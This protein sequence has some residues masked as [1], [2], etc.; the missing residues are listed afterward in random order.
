MGSNLFIQ[1]CKQGDFGD[2]DE[3]IKLK[4]RLGCKSFD[5][6][7]KNVAYD[8]FNPKISIAEGEVQ[9]YLHSCTKNNQNDHR[10]RYV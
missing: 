3:Q 5:W 2:V 4:N 8:H 1:T 7:M 9:F 10:I 6:Y